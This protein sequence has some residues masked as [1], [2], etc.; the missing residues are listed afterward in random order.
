MKKLYETSA[1]QKIK[2]ESFLFLFYLSVCN[3]IETNLELLKNTEYFFKK[4]KRDY[5]TNLQKKKTAQNFEFR[6]R[7]VIKLNI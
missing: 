7:S 2:S 1:F 4:R 6:E 3:R 5:T